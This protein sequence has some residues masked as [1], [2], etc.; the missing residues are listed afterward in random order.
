MGALTSA[1]NQGGDLKLAN[2][3]PPVRELLKMTKLHTVFDVRDD[4]ASAMQA[5]SKG[6]AAAG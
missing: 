2:P 6:V 1:R 4:E 3:T 5:F